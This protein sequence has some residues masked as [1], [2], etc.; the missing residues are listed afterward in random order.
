MSAKCLKFIF[1]TLF[2]VVGIRCQSQV[3]Q[4][5]ITQT[6]EKYHNSA[7]RYL[8]ESKIEITLEEALKNGY[9]ACKVCKPDIAN[10]VNSADNGILTAKTYA[11][12]KSQSVQCSGK[13]KKGLRCKRITTASNGRCYQH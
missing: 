12:K 4:V 1:I 11:P 8:K 7:C 10:S 2:L 5:Y 9:G 3:Q 6:G 13:T